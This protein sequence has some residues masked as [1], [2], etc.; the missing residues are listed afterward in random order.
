MKL[1]VNRDRD[2]GG[3]HGD[4][5]EDH[6]ADPVDAGHRR[7]GRGRRLRVG[8]HGVGGARDRDPVRRAGSPH[9]A[10][11]GDR[12]ARDAERHGRCVGWNI[13]IN[14]IETLL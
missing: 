6:A 11:D 4:G 9:H 12:A 2:G 1:T 10:A 13:F 14:R 3:G 7:A 5:V 8:V